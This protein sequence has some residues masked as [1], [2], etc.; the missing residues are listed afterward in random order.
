[1]LS[2]RLGEAGAV[3]YL[4][5]CARKSEAMTALGP[6]DG[7]EA[8]VR[9]LMDLPE[10]SVEQLIA[11]Q[12]GDSGFDCDLLKA[13]A[14]ANRR[15]GAQTGIGHAEVIE[16]WLALPPIE[17]AVRLD[18]LRKVVLTDKNTLRVSAGQAKAEPHYEAHAG[19]LAVLIGDL[20]RVQNGVR[21]A[22]DIAAAL[23][24]GQAF[25]AAYAQAKRAAGVAGFNDLIA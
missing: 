19:R 2:R 23:R 18:D 5:A 16:T 25:S 22:S 13:V 12:C 7:I 24:A 4:Q 3:E 10:G 1:C 6:T 21:L 15:W 14:D 20:L 11:D 17:R 8:A 9:K